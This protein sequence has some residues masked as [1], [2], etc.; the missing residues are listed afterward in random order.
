M[1]IVSTA[2]ADLT[3]AFWRAANRGS[4]DR[5]AAEPTAEALH[6]ELV[7]LDSALGR[8]DA[9]PATAKQ[10]ATLRGVPM[11][12]TVRAPSRPTAE[13]GKAVEL[14]L[15]HVRRTGIVP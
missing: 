3:V 1:A 2:A 10:L 13:V 8:G 9:Y 4:S 7:A 14:W 12:T 6:E 11:S 5:T 15:S